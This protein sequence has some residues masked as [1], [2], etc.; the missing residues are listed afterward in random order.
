MEIL[1]STH[2]DLE[3]IFN[4]YDAAIA[5]QK[6]VSHMH[7]LPFDTKLVESEIAENR[8]WKIIVDGQVA[9]VFVTAYTDAAIWGEKDRDPS[10][11]LHR[12]VT[13]PNFR[14]RNFVGAIVEWALHHGASMGKKFVRLDTW[15]ENLKLKEIYL[16]NGF[17]FLGNAAPAD[18]SAL[19]SHYSGIVL[20]F[21]EI[22]ID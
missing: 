8:Q 5:H 22:L 15:A 16:R 2:S 18:P 9:C 13:N 3:T 17:R 7:W 21:Y 6:V 12:I 11:Y 19:P 10:V 4:L 1:N 14:G 20:G